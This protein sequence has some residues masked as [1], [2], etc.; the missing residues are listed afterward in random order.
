MKKFLL[1]PVTFGLLIA[2]WV[3]AAGAVETKETVRNLPDG[4]TEV[5]RYETD[6]AQAQDGALVIRTAW[7]CERKPKASGSIS[8]AQRVSERSVTTKAG[9]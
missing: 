4:S 7:R 3:D 5:C 8:E 6:F 1:I 2:L 9:K